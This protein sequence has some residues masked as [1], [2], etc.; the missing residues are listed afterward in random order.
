MDKNL[1]EIKPIFCIDV[2][3][4]KKND[5]VNGAE[6]VARTVT[7]GQ[8]DEY[9]ETR[10]QLE[11]TINK[12]QLPLWLR[13]AKLIMGGF[14]IIVFAACIKPGFET[15]WRNASYLIIS[16]IVCAA[17]WV[18]LHVYSKSKEKK[19]LT[20]EDVI[21]QLEKIDEN[22]NSIL[23]ELNVP[24]YAEDVDVLVFKYKMKNGEMR[25]FTHA[26]QTTPYICINLK[27]FATEDELCISDVENVY[28]FKK[29]DIKSIITVDKRIGISTWN[30]EEEPRKGRFAPYKMTVSNT[31]DV[32]FKPYYILEIEIEN[33]S[34]GL[35]FPCYELGVIERFTGLMAVSATN[36]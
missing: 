36:D 26:M 35:Y 2:T 22:T 23:E 3:A 24:A 11:K 1:N 9:E 33:Q 31:G 13:I 15:A 20:E 28:Y 14:S 21:G 16:A 10:V 32:Y 8:K 7:A 5:V 4:D 17:L 6:F 29:T 27:I 34:Y 18:I 12:S 30:K 25:P 19:V